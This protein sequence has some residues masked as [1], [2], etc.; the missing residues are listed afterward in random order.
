M[1]EFKLPKKKVFI[2]PVYKNG[3]FAKS[4]EKHNLFALNDASITLCP[5][6]DS[7]EKKVRTGLTEVEQSYLEQKMGLKEGELDPFYTNPYWMN[8]TIK[9]RLGAEALNLDV[10][11][12]Y[13]K[14]AILR[15]SDKVAESEEMITPTSLFYIEDV[16]DTAERLAS[17]AE[18]KEKAVE[19]FVALTEE[20]RKTIMKIYGHDVT[21]ATSKFI[22]GTLFQLMEDN[23]AKFVEINSQSKE[24]IAIQAFIH[25]LKNA[26]VL[27]ERAGAYFDKDT[28][29]GTLSDVVERLLDP[30]HQEEYLAYKERLQFTVGNK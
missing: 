26:G 2:K 6:I 28:N 20:G 4:L 19:M 9:L 25:D 7:Y 14:Y 23:P 3:P 29:L 27:R 11:T 5:D 17:K 18:I 24:R 21:N 10:P 1:G 15:A 8:Y 30:S 22:K 12:D 16:V 13:L